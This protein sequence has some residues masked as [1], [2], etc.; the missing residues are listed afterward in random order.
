M[1]DIVR[2]AR[3]TSGTGQTSTTLVPYDRSQGQAGMVTPTTPG[4]GK[5]GNVISA[6][7]A[8]FGRFVPSRNM[9]ITKIAFYVSTA[10]GADDAFSVGIYTPSGADLQVVSKTGALTNASVEITSGGGL[11]ASAGVRVITLPTPAALT[12]GTVYYNAFSALTPFG[13]TAAQL[14]HVTNLAAN[15]STMFGTTPGTGIEH[16]AKS[17]SHPLADTVS[18]PVANIL[19]VVMAMRES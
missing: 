13:G 16:C 14:I 5:L 19:A 4:A 3:L 6:G 10:A 17:S 9:T 11:A 7:W 2:R 12:A 15:H 18:A 8:V 1:P